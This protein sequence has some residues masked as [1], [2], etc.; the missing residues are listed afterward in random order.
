MGVAGS[1]LPCGVVALS[2]LAN[3]RHQV[4]VIPSVEG[5]DG[6]GVTTFSESAPV[7]VACNVHPVSASESENFGL[8][9]VDTYKITAPAGTWLWGANTVVVYDG[10]RFSQVG[11]V[12]KSRIGSATRADRVFIERG[13]NG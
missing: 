5:I 9:L 2:L 3:P 1:V 6:D 12:R 7:S 10:E 11:R 4:T 13:Q 8:K